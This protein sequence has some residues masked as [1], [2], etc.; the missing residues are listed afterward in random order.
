MADAKKTYVAPAYQKNAAMHEI[1]GLSY[2]YY[3]YYY[4]Y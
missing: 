3:Y 2:Y 4:Y 1:T